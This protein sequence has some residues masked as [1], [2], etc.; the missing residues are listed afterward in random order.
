MALRTSCN[1]RLGRLGVAV[2]GKLGECGLQVNTSNS[3]NIRHECLNAVVT[4]VIIV[5]ENRVWSTEFGVLANALSLEE[6][7][8]AASEAKSWNN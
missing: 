2:I 7:I 4:A 3:L 8:V 6:G 1:L 5:L